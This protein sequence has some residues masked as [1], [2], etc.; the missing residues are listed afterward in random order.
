SCD[1]VSEIVYVPGA[2]MQTTSDVAGTPLLQLP[3]V[4]QSPPAVF[5]HVSVHDTEMACADGIA[6]TVATRK[7]A[8]TITRLRL[9][10]RRRR[11][12]VFGCARRDSDRCIVGGSNGVMLGEVLTGG[13]RAG[14]GQ[15]GGAA[16]D[17]G[18]TRTDV[19]DLAD[20]LTAL[21][22]LGRQ[23]QNEG[24]Q[25]GRDGTNGAY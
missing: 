9:P 8:L 24:L 6:S 17:R 25:H 11:C 19:L 1:E 16:D 10:T 3:A 22:R 21:K 20:D 18:Q 15:I 4:D 7:S 12:G 23:P 2:V 5:V 14:G 13:Q